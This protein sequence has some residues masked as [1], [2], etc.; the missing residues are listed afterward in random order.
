MNKLFDKFKA[1][2]KLDHDTKVKIL[3]G[4]NLNKILCVDKTS[5]NSVLDEEMINLESKNST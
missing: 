4:S 5:Y 1:D 2:G 3:G